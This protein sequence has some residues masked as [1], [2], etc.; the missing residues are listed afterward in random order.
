MAVAIQEM[1]FEENSGFVS[2][3]E[4]ILTRAE[5]LLSQ[6]NEFAYEDKL[7]I[8]DVLV[9][10]S[11]EKISDLNQPEW[12]KGNEDEWNKLLKE[13]GKI[14]S[15][16]VKSW[17]ACLDEGTKYVPDNR[18]LQSF[19]FQ[20]EKIL[21]GIRDTIKVIEMLDPEH[22]LLNSMR[23]E[24]DT[25]ESRMSSL[26]RLP[27]NQRQEGMFNSI[28]GFKHYCVGVAF[29]LV[30][31]RVLSL[32]ENV[33]MFGFLDKSKLLSLMMFLKFDIN[34]E[35]FPEIDKL[36][37]RMHADRKRLGANL[38]RSI[39]ELDSQIKEIPA[40]DSQPEEID[41]FQSPQRESIDITDEIFNLSRQ[42][43][44]ASPSD[45]KNR[46]KHH[47]ARQTRKDKFKKK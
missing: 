33:Q 44:H 15:Y 2:T 17:F 10:Y 12:F 16:K 38:V 14:P 30:N 32:Y 23:Q 5:S 13:E 45:K 24:L 19:Q 43:G 34:W 26:Y 29:S 40:L 39:K 9:A 31:L 47:A 1:Q 3:I 22:E 35:N 18:E 20:L 21:D 28:K 46:E 37:I 36:Q 11:S 4:I 42:S 7:R 25:R 8:I 41:H 6:I 27:D